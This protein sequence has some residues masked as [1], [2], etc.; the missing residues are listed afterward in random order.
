MTKKDL[1]NKLKN[2]VEKN[3]EDLMGNENE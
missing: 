1:K 2:Q 3:I